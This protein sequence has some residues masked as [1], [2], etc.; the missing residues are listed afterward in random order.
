MKIALALY[1]TIKN[2]I[3]AYEGISV[4][5]TWDHE[6]F[7]TSGRALLRLR[8]HGK[9]MKVYLDINAADYP[10]PKFPLIDESRRKIESTTNTLLNVK[11]PRMVKYAM[12]LIDDIANKRGLV[13]NEDYVKQ[14]F[15]VKALD[16]DKLIKLELIKSK[17][18]N[19]TKK[20]K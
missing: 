20:A 11:G 8:Y 6:I 14:D 17:E 15:K 19:L 1:N 5:Q 10:N 2:H 7:T 9:T 12:E 18:V 16:R 13:K 3:L 4:N